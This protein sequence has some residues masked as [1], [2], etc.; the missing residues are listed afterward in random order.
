MLAAR[1]GEI[2]IHREALWQLG[3]AAKLKAVETYA[4]RRHHPFERCINTLCSSQFQRDVKAHGHFTEYDGAPSARDLAETTPESIE[5]DGFFKIGAGPKPFAMFFCLPSAFAAH[6]NDWRVLRAAERRESLTQFKPGIL[7]HSQVKQNRV[8]IML[9]RQRQAVFRFTRVHTL[10]G[11]AQF[12]ADQPSQG[13]IVVHNQQFLHCC[14][15]LIALIA[16]QTA[17][18][19]SF[20][21][22]AFSSRIVVAV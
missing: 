14:S 19:I 15:S 7:G 20:L 5:V 17:L 3:Y 1:T 10:V 8:G 16:N 22:V 13:A 4:F 9:E 6:D 11:V 18:L 21:S 12:D 2:D